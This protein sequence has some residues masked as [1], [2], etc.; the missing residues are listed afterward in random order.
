MAA[1]PRGRPHLLAPNSAHSPVARARPHWLTAGRRCPG[2]AEPHLRPRMPAANQKSQ[3]Q[4]SVSDWSR[5]LPPP[6]PKRAAA[7]WSVLQG[8]GAL[9]GSSLRGRSQDGAGSG[10]PAGGTGTGTRTHLLRRH[11]RSR[12]APPG[13]PQSC[14]APSGSGLPP[15]WG[16]VEGPGGGEEGPWGGPPAPHRGETGSTSQEGG[17][18]TRARG[19]PHCGVLGES[20]G[21]GSRGS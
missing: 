15:C 20:A 13:C 11:R 12:G 5:C 4:K 9:S 21:R 16:A 1:A 6:H 18:A 3:L 19:D 14:R 17:W 7:P 8:G 10:I 2:R